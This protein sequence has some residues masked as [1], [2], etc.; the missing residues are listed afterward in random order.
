MMP[1]AWNVH[2]Q[3]ICFIVIKQKFG[4]DAVVILPN[5]VIPYSSIYIF[6]RIFLF[7][8]WVNSFFV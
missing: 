5:F 2:S 8:D 4:A 1:M 6:I 7:Y 3:A